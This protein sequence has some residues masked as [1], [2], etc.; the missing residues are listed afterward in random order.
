MQKKA[1]TKNCN[2]RLMPRTGIAFFLLAVVSLTNIVL[3]QNEECTPGSTVCA[4]DS[5]EVTTSDE[6]ERLKSRVKQFLSLDDSNPITRN[7]HIYFNIVTEILPYDALLGLAAEVAKKGIEV[8]TVENLHK[9]HQD[10]SKLEILHQQK[11]EFGRLYSQYAWILYKKN[12]LENA[13]DNIKKAM[14]YI[15]SPTPDDYLR[16]G[17]IEYGKGK[18]QQGWDH[19]TKALVTDTIVEVEDPGYRKAIDKVIKDKFGEEQDP[20]AFIAE[21]RR[22]NTEMIPNLILVTLENTKIKTHQYD[23]QVIF[24][25]FFSPRC[26]SCKQEIAS[27]KNLHERFSKIND[28]VFI[29]ILNWPNLKQEAIDLFEKSGINKPVIAVLEKGTAWDLIP[30][31]P[32]IW[33]T[34]KAGKI[35]FRHTG[36]KQGD[37]LI[38][39]R[40]LSRLIQD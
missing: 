8:N 3:S 24:V 2:L 13:F 6:I 30:G 7:S 5:K 25:N 26:G 20:A 1:K 12:Q 4:T 10:M 11:L 27:L 17:I 38:Y 29:F 39:Q 22:Q 19:I 21:Y 40:K 9:T 16:L 36:Y 33:I 15:S 14:S 35:A 28:V 34:D 32:S 37:E 18:K 23:G 31:E